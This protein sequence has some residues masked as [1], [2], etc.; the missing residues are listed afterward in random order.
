LV[1]EYKTAPPKALPADTKLCP[2]DLPV[3]LPPDDAGLE[4]LRK[5]LKID[6]I[7]LVGCIKSRRNLDT[8]EEKMLNAYAGIE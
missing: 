7:T 3:K 1:T 6:R 8:Y 2:R 5:V 4:T